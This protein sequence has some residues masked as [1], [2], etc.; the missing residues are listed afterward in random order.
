MT[1]VES[2]LVHLDNAWNHDWDSLQTVLAGLTDAE[3]SWQA[4]SYAEE[5]AEA[6]TIRWQIAHIADCK[7]AYTARIQ[8]DIAAR[9][10]DVPVPASADLAGDLEEL[11]NAHEAQRE[12]IAGMTD[13]QMTP[14][15]VD[16]LANTIRHDIWHAGQI[17]IARRL[18]RTRA[19][20]GQSS[21]I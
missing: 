21:Y 10:P 11:R 16:F 18:W 2:I 4:P 12:A 20:P 14:V 3:A 15:A 7:R 17:A 13:D 1:V 8:G 5:G 9:T 6:G 19:S